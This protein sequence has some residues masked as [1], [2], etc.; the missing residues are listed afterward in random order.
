MGAAQHDPTPTP[1][2]YD[3]GTGDR[4]PTPAPTASASDHNLGRFC[5]DR[6]PGGV[7]IVFLDGHART[8]ALPE[9]WQLRW[10]KS[11]VPINVK[12]TDPLLK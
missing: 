5:L 4:I 10:N 11:F 7:N 8:V 2:K 12:G 3:L 1:G 6:H 9:L